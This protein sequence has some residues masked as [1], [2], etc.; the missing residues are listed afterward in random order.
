L[1]P[2]PTRKG[3]AIN[4]NYATQIETAPPRFVIFANH[5]E[6]VHFSYIR[7]LENKLR[8]AFG[9]EGAPIEIEVRRKGE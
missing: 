5:P 1:N 9:F 3:R 7:Y 8:E 6:L 2:P 4:I